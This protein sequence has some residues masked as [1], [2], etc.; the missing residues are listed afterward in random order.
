MTYKVW[1]FMP[2]HG[3]DEVL[4]WKTDI[5]RT[6]EGEQ[7]VMLRNAPR[8][9]LSY[10][11]L[12]N[13]HTLSKARA[14][15][16]GWGGGQ[17]GIPVWTEVIFV[18]AVSSSAT[19]ITVDTTTSEYVVGGQVLI[20]QDDSNYAE[21]TVASITS[22]QL[23]LSGAVGKTFTAAY[24]C[25]LRMG[26]MVDGFSIQRGPNTNFKSSA[27]FRVDDNSAYAAA[28]GFPTL[29]G[30][31]I[32]TD[33]MY[34]LGGADEKIIREVEVMDNLTGKVYAPVKYA[35]SDQTFYVGF[36]L[37]TR[38]D[39]KRIRSWL[40]TNKG[41][42]TPFWLISQSS[43]LTLTSDVGAADTSIEVDSIGYGGNYTQT[44]IRILRT[45]GTATYHR[46][47]SG[48]TVGSVDVLNLSAAAG[49]AATIAGTE[50]I[51]FMQCVRLDSDRVEISHQENH[52]ASI[53]VPCIEVPVP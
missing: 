19:S 20:W 2:Q 32:L 15:A 26:K 43:D 16:Y 30:L 37:Q 24:V 21:A 27:E 40:H 9:F 41:R 31:E 33:T 29:L 49:V 47:S 22:T 13:E 1:P 35:R 18:G 5:L 28:S 38:T 7:R 6:Y 11:F 14:L 53:K 3:V 25:P 45:N 23:N 39:I 42:L 50:S 17:F 4:E 36:S 52:Y 48:S 51:S 34:H 8:Q 46:V 44:A 10:T 12:M